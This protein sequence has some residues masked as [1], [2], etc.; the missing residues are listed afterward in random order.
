MQALTVYHSD[1]IVG[2]KFSTAS[3][4]TVHGI[5]RWNETNGW[6]ALGAGIADS[7]DGV[8]ALTVYGDD[9]FVAGGFN[10]AGGLT[11]HGIARWNETDGWRTLGSGIEDSSFC[12]Y[13]LAVYGD[14]L[15]VGGAFTMAGSVTAN[16]IAR[17]SGANGWRTLGTGM[18]DNTVYGYGLAVRALA[19]YGTDL[20]AGGDFTTAGGITCNRIARWDGTSWL[21]TGGGMNGSVYSLAV[22]G[23][24]LVAGGEFRAA[25][26]VPVSFIARGVP[27]EDGGGLYPVS[28]VPFARYV[29]SVPDTEDDSRRLHVAKE[30]AGSPTAQYDYTYTYAY[31]SAQSEMQSQGE[32]EPTQ[33]ATWQLTTSDKDGN[34]ARIEVLEKSEYSSG[35]RTETTTVLAVDGGQQTAAH[36]ELR[37]Y[38]NIAPD[39]DRFERH[40]GKGGRSRRVRSNYNVGLLHHH[41]R[42]RQEVRSP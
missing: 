29:V 7:W 24:Q 1:L 38:V 11:V 30:L 15:I 37:T 34:P 28:G 14:E 31:A 12:V 42:S 3:G 6:R 22:N 23:T 18:G 8:N 25:G 21:S 27:G 40:D 26:G 32:S 20:V 17:W 2:G 13:A 41:R 5:A 4:L 9:L 39:A 36:K 16:G 35:I 10:T 19:L 33:T